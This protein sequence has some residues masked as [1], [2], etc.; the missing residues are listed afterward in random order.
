M[1]IINYITSAVVSIS[2]FLATNIVL[3]LVSSSL[4]INEFTCHNVILVVLLS[5]IISL[6]VSKDTQ[7]L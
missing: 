4:S 1:E 3:L 5:R 2:P 7:Y 6:K